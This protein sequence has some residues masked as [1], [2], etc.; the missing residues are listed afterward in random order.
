MED[1][2][3]T[4]NTVN[5][6]DPVGV[7]LAQYPRLPFCRLDLYTSNVSSVL[8]SSMVQYES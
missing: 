2:D 8:G 5:T 3:G 4:P 7:Y 6:A 1:E